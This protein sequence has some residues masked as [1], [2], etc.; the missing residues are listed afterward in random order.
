MRLFIYKHN[1]IW[2]N[3]CQTMQKV[4]FVIAEIN[5]GWQCPICKHIFSPYTNECP[6]CIVQNPAEYASRTFNEAKNRGLKA[7]QGPLTQ[8]EDEIQVDRDQIRG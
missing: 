1:R 5:T 2:Y 3:T 4:V 6:Y 7:Y 8:S